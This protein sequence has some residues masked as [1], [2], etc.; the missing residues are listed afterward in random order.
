MRHSS[1][2]IIYGPV[3][4]DTPPLTAAGDT[5]TPWPA[6]HE[7]SVI[8]GQASLGDRPALLLLLSLSP[9]THK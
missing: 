4:R 9:W 2:L 1:S 6:D 7:V 3:E 5:Q 8:T